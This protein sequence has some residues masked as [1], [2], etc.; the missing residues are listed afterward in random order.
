MPTITFLPRCI[1][2]QA[3]TDDI[4]LKRMGF[5]EDG[6]NGNPVISDVDCT[7]CAPRREGYISDAQH[8]RAVQMFEQRMATLERQHRAMVQTYNRRN[9]A[10][11]LQPPVTGPN[12]ELLYF[13][14][15]ACKW[16]GLRV[17]DPEVARREYDAHACSLVDADGQ[18]QPGQTLHR[19][20]EAPLP[21]SWAAETK[22]MLAPK[23]EILPVDDTPVVVTTEVDGTEQ[24]MKL[25]ELK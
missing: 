14:R 15:C 20:T 12:G 6:E 23:V 1:G 2:V 25:L 11:A 9:R 17:A 19:K 10:V 7:P 4:A 5:T 8:Q 18:W 16:H 22:A 13:T 3:V 21:A 24:R